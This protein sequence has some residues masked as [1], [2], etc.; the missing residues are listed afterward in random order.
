MGDRNLKMLGIRL[1]R[2]DELLVEALGYRMELVRQVGAHKKKNG[3][4]IIRPKVERQRI[5]RVCAL[6]HEYGMNPDFVGAIWYMII[7]ESCRLQVAQLQS[8]DEGQL[9][10]AKRNASRYRRLQAKFR[11]LVKG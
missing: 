9:M 8:K 11:R 6:A 7:A 10:H 1:T 2:A 5:T 3:Q 4:K